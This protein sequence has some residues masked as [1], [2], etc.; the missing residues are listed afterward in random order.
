MKKTDL[1]KNKASK[2]LGQMRQA[3]SS[4][5]FGSAAASVPDR[6]EQRKID[7]ANNLVPFAVKLN[8]D[9]VKQLH[10]HAEREGVLMTEFVD[11]VIRAGLLAK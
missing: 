11:R 2:I 1:E 6:R 7:Q 9:L 8:A 4:G 5:R 10:S 3:P